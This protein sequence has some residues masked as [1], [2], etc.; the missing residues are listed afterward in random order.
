MPSSG[1][2]RNVDANQKTANTTA[3]MTPT[4]HVGNR[5]INPMTRAC[6]SHLSSVDIVPLASA[7]VSVI[8]TALRRGRVR[9]PVWALVAALLAGATA[10]GVPQAYGTLTERRSLVEVLTAS[11]SLLALRGVPDGTGE[12]ASAFIEVFTDLGLT[13]GLVSV[14]LVTRHTRADEET[15]RAELVRATPVRRRSPVVAAATAAS[16][17]PSR[18][19]SSSPWP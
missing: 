12:G 3:A 19:A 6:R 4:I 1:I 14:F 8:E 5:L 18:S 7:R 11:P 15:G 2:V 13:A 17:R 9:I 16:S 10:A